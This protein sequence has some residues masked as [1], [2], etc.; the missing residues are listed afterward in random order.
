MEEQERQPHGWHWPCPVHR[1]ERGTLPTRTRSDQGPA[2][3]EPLALG[4]QLQPGW[5][6]EQALIPTSS[7][8]I[9]EMPAALV[10][11]QRDG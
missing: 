9:C 10:G 5:P 1:Q 3:A 4:C 8:N 11:V 2:K 6:H 7:L